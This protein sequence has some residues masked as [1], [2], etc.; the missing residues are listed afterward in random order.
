MPTRGAIKPFF[1]HCPVARLSSAAACAAPIAFC[2]SGA[3]GVGCINRW[4]RGKRRILW[5]STVE[6]GPSPSALVAWRYEQRKSRGG[7]ILVLLCAFSSNCNKVQAQALGS[8]LLS[9]PHFMSRE[10]EALSSAQCLSLEH[11]WPTCLSQKTGCF[12]SERIVSNYRREGLEQTSSALT[13]VVGPSS[14]LEIP[15]LS[16]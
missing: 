9:H 11:A 1:R 15:C 10:P 14:C 7:T 3:W 6:G 13:Y 8:S 5:Q 2:C 16:A 4:S 12:R